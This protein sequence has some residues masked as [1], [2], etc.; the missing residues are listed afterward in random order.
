MH[1]P[2]PPLPSAAPF[3]SLVLQPF[4]LVTSTQKRVSPVG[5]QST[6]CTVVPSAAAGPVLWEMGSLCLPKPL[7]RGHRDTPAWDGSEPPVGTGV[8][9]RELLGAASATLHLWPFL[10]FLA[11]LIN[12][13]H[14]TQSSVT[15]TLPNACSVCHPTAQNLLSSLSFP[16]E[17]PHP[18]S[19]FQNC[20][21]FV[22]S[23]QHP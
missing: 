5:H 1:P 17:T 23:P 7:L 4:S 15:Q 16:R 22:Q 19:P 2:A 13:E 9:H 21:P 6:D 12:T 10:R 3:H 20:S 14:P 8:G 11:S 18:D